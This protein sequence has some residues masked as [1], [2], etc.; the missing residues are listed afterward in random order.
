MRP[1]AVIFESSE[2]SLVIAHLRQDTRRKGL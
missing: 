2:K 1:A